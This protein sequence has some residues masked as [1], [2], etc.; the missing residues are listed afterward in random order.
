[1]EAAVAAEAADGDKKVR[2]ESERIT[3]QYH[4]VTDLN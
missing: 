1:V 2:V 3:Q 4:V